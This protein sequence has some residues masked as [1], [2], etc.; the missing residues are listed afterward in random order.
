MIPTIGNALAARFGNKPEHLSGTLHHVTNCNDDP[1]PG[2]GSLRSI[3]ADSMTVSGDSIDF[4]QLPMMCS[5]ITLTGAIGIHQDFLYLQGP[6]AENLTIDASGAD[7]VFK[8]FGTTLYVNDLTIAN[9]SLLPP[10]FP[11]AG[12]STRPATFFSPTPSSITAALRAA[13]S[14]GRRSAAVFSPRMISLWCAAQSRTV[15]L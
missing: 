9:G 7:S 4:A 11:R 1:A 8:H 13:T 12:A 14:T 6:G 3:V 5:K 10:M 2:S 15:S